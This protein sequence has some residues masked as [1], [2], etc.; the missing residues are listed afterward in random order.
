MK[1]VFTFLGIAI[2]AIVFAS[3]CEKFNED[4]F[5]TLKSGSGPSQVQLAMRNFPTIDLLLN[6][7]DKTIAFSFNE[8]VNYEQSHN[9][10]SF[11]RQADQV[12]YG[13]D[14]N[15]LTSDAAILQIISQNSDYIQKV[16]KNGEKYVETILY[17]NIF[18]YVVNSEK[19]VRVDTLLF[20]A[21]ENGLITCH[22]NHYSE[23]L[24]ITENDFT[25]MQ[26]NRT[27]TVIPKGG[28]STVVPITTGFGWSQTRE[29]TNSNGKEKV[30]IE[31]YFTRAIPDAMVNG[32]HHV[33]GKFV[34]KVRGYRKFLW[35]W[36]APRTLT[37]NICLSTNV[38]KYLY[39]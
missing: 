20:K 24:Q 19:M 36:P 9:F 25:K 15:F 23:L 16:E 38:Y 18:R 34:V 28:S 27:F 1:K 39:Q 14:T 22:F 7:I 4:G 8:L 32:Q 37:A 30:K 21:F 13:I 6:E 5:G 2:V 11:G 31:A 12:L 35:F 33:T 10:S 17:N 3:S 26:S 29:V